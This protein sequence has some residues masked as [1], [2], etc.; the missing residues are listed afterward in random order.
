[1]KLRGIFSLLAFAAT[2]SIVTAQV[3]PD[4]YIAV[5]KDE[6]PNPRAAARALAAQ[7][8][9]AVGYVYE[10][11][12]KG[13][14]FG[15]SPQAAA[16]LTK[17][18]EIA[19]VEQEQVFHAVGDVAVLPT[20]I[21]RA[22]VDVAMPIATGQGVSLAGAP[23]TV[24]VLDTGAEASH[25]D[26]NIIG[27]IRFYTRGLRVVSDGSYADGNGHGTHVSGTIGAKDDGVNFEGK[28]VVGV[29]P[30]V[31]IYAVKVL[32][33]SGS[34]YTSA[35]VAGIDHVVANASTIAVANMS[36]GGGVSQAL[37]DAVKRGTDAGIVFVVAAGN[38]SADVS[39]SSPAR[40]PSAI[41]VSALADSDGT[42]EGR[43]PS[44]Y[45]SDGTFYT[46]DDT[47]APFS[48][49]GAGV[50]ICAPG[51]LILSTV[52]GGGYD[53]SYSGTSM[54]APH[55]TGAAALYIAVHGIAK[56]AAGVEAIA[57][58]LRTS[59]W[60]AGEPEYILSGDPDKSR[61]PLLNVGRLMGTV[62][63][64]DAPPTV[65]I[66]SPAEG[67]TVSGNS[68]VVTVDAS[69][70]KGVGK[71]EFFVNGTS[72]GIDMNGDNGW[73]FS[74]DLTPVKDDS[75]VLT[76]IATDTIGQTTTSDPVS[77][78]VDNV[79]DPVTHVHCGDLDGSATV[80]RKNW[81]ATVTVTIHDAS[82]AVVSGA[83]VTGSWSGGYTG[84]AVGTTGN[85]GTVM[86]ASGSMNSKK[87]SVTFTIT[88]VSGAG[89]TYEPKSNHDA[90]GDSN[91]TVIT[92]LKP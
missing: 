89:L 41:T 56:N 67:A 35:I 32:D 43:G 40:A 80:S 51:V 88:G 18:A 47:F 57:N 3:V 62:E 68:V 26:L 81:S 2:T 33:D 87:T 59:G 77:V 12:L 79:T 8:G 45:L 91:G 13:F 66:T 1:M 27:G 29:A 9:V 22:E 44:F 5:F 70:D 75:Y 54:A 38:S 63:P 69:D 7:H 34:G 61:E 78:I 58:A 92:V 90:D 60:H 55:V 46:A 74:W 39:T 85:D 11:A 20:G 24:A 16:A 30:G 52:P 65:S 76:A 19:Y 15:G 48:N 42:P 84:V 73:S 31:K 37:D 83:T 36:L 6:L 49:Y 23:V 10:H 14:A 17:R 50:D 86:F 28:E 25:P 4:R 21:N 64:P 71:V 72:I 53:G 82:H